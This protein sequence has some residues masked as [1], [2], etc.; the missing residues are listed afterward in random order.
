MLTDEV[1][2]LRQRRHPGHLNRM[3]LRAYQFH[4]QIQIHW[5]PLKMRAILMIQI[6]PHHFYPRWSV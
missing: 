6:Y 4:R 2:E 5:M 1:A 3:K